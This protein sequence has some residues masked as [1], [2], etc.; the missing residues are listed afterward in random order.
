MAH[1]SPQGRLG[2]WEAEGGAHGEGWKGG[3][4]KGRKR[5]GSGRKEKE[6]IV[7]FGR[8]GKGD[9]AGLRTD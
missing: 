6:K 9:D 3:R 1:A 2:D 7:R 8:G 5:G 4:T